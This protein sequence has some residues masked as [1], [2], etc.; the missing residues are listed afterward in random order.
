M[1]QFYFDIKIIQWFFKSARAIPIV[2]KKV[3]KNGLEIALEKVEERLKEGEM[4]AL[5]P[6][7]YI[8]K[9]GELLPFKPGIE[10]MAKKHSDCLIIPLA[11]SGMWGSWFSRHINQRAMTGFPWRRSFRT[12]LTIN[13]G[14]PIQ[15]RDLTTTDLEKKIES[16]RGNIK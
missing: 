12:K 5:F 6:E 2:P 11:I 7:A 15:S 3:C 16:L 4:V 13:I 1:D 8:T 10:Q 9:T 14:S